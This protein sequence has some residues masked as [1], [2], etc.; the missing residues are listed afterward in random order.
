MKHITSSF[1]PKKPR[2]MEEGAREGWFGS[3]FVPGRGS[4]SRSKSQRRNKHHEMR[5]LSADLPF[6]PRP[7][8]HS[9]SFTDTE[10]EFD[11]SDVATPSTG[12]SDLFPFPF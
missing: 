6:N 3:D 12:N 2:D 8:F 4:G 11:R 7:K 10:S 9:S 5:Q 1:P